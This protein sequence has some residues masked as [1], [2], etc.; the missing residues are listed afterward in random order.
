MNPLGDPALPSR[1]GTRQAALEPGAQCLQPVVQAEELADRD[2]QEERTE[3]GKV[4]AGPCRRV[5][6]D[7]DGHR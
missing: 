2:A 6:E 5:A 1:G 4:V 7:A 3:H